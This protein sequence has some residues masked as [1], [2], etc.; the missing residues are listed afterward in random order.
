MNQAYEIT[1]ILHDIRSVHNVGSIFRTAD[2]IGVKKIYL[3]GYTPTPLDRFQRH[4]KDLA[5]VA[6]GAEKT[7]PWEQ[8]KDIYKLI[9]DLKKNNTEIIALEQSNNSIDY[10]THKPKEKVTLILGNEPEGIKKD[11][12]EKT[13][14]T[15]EIPM[16]GKKESLN[17]AVATGIALFSLFD[18]K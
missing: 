18:K 15:I 11:I 5:K 8:K 13:D 1:L 12:L 4:R 14:T 2:A 9:D 7:I 10:K 3:T 6:L 17:V 16:Y